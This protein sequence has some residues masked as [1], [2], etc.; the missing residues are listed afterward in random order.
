[1]RKLLCALLALTVIFSLSAMAF[2][3]DGDA[4]TDYPVS[5]IN[6]IVPFKAGGG[7]DNVM[8][9]LASYA[10]DLCGVTMTITNM[11]GASGATGMAYV[12]EQASDGYTIL[13]TA[14]SPCLYDAMDTGD[15]TYDDFEQ[16][17]LVGAE[18]VF[19]V[20]REDS[21]Y[22]TLEDLVDYA[23]ENPE[24]LTLPI[25]GPAALGAI[26]G[27]MLNY[28]TGASFAY[29]PSEGDGDAFAQLLSGQAD[30]VMSK[31]ST[32]GG[33]Y[34]SGDIRIL[35]V[36][37]DTR[38][39]NFPDC[40]AITEIYPDFS[41]CLPFSSFYCVS[42]KKDT[43]AEI[44]SYLKDLFKEAFE[45]EEYQTYLTDVCAME[46]M[47]YIGEDADEYINSWRKSVITALY[48]AGSVAHSPEDLG[49]E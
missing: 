31:T 11:A 13:M 6:W 4:G 26:V 16:I 7:T 9:P 21:P 2:A 49:I 48:A 41:D 34:D 38:M 43:P 10:S 5:D 1:M 8:R 15:Y 44:I 3:A 19:I 42:V 37:N 17:C 27:A 14:E 33:Y 12:A 18:T 24:T 32:V 20:V 47:G 39:E 36:V 29:T 40:P 35:A 46:P 45:D 30:V 22:Q 25:S 23:V 28:T